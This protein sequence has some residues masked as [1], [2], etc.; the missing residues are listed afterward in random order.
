MVTGVAPI[1]RFVL[2]MAVVGASFAPA[3]FAPKTALACSCAIA[4]DPADLTFSDTVFAGT[5]VE[6]AQWDRT[7]SSATLL[8]IIF[9]VDHAWAGDAQPLTTARTA[10]AGA[11]CGYAFEEGVRYLVYGKARGDYVEVNLCS[12]TRPYDDAAVQAL[13]AV[14]G[15]GRT[16]EGPAP[17]SVGIHTAVRSEPPQNAEDS[18]RGELTLAALVAVTAGV[19]GAAVI[20]FRRRRDA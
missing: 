1:V 13:E 14:A 3:L 8:P 15:Q 17:G 6:V 9:T 11:S 12:P 5:A 18:H 10:A 16:V 2:V 20:A 4:P 19:A 7:G